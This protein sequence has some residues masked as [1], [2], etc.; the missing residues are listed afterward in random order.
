MTED[1]FYYEVTNLLPYRSDKN[2]N[3]V[4][5]LRN[6]LKTYESLLI[7]YGISS[8]LS[9]EVAYITKRLIEIVKNY[10]KG[11]QSTAYIK[12]QN[13]IQGK[14]GFS[15]KIDLL[16]TILPFDEKT[17][18]FYRIR[19][20]DSIYEI[21]AKEMFHI[22]I[23]K[24]GIVKTQR[25]SAI[26][27]PCLYLGESIYGCWEEMRRPSMQKCAVSRLECT[28]KLNIIDL[29]IP[30]KQSLRNEETLK[31]IPLLIACMMPVASYEDSYKPEYIIP[32]LI[33]EWILKNRKR[34]I[35]GVCY[36]STH[37]N[38]EFKFPTDKF[39][40]YAIPA[41]DINSRH[42]Y[43][44][45][46][47]EMFKITKPTTNDIE[48]LKCGYSINLGGAGLSEDKQRQQN[49]KSSDFGHLEERLNDKNEFELYDI[50]YK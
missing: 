41:Y 45:K 31:L 11:L 8:Q 1:D 22:P 43:C 15:P 14:K 6:A 24:R 37:I 21:E 9:S 4:G 38:D 16:K 50:N 47:C 30:S 49:Y 20:L 42:K 3:F 28:S 44:K 34:D 17:M 36:T 7:E 19:L 13:L 35:D 39:I 18:S 23:N 33:I 2:N 46:L 25:Y 40:N 12:L 29:T 10:E 32:Q 26:G 27:Y 48:K 5:R